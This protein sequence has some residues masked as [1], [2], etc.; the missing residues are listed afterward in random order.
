MTLAEIVQLKPAEF[1]KY[2]R[3]LFIE[4]M[5][6]E[7]ERCADTITSQATE[8]LRLHAVE[9]EHAAL[10][11]SKKMTRTIIGV[12]GLAT[13]TGS[14][15]MKLTEKEWLALGLALLIIAAL[16]QITIAIVDGK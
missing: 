10:K 3:V 8:I 9:V 16:I 15:L 1:A 4:N 14:A 5:K 11:K 13:A 6:G 2:E 7:R 12:C